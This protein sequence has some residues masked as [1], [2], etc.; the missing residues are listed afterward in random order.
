[1]PLA[2]DLDPGCFFLARR[3]P[4]A[5]H[6][7][8][9]S[10]DHKML[11]F[12]EQWMFDPLISTLC[13]S[14]G[15]RSHYCRAADAGTTRRPHFIFPAL[16]RRR[17]TVPLAGF[18]P[19]GPSLGTSTD[20]SL[21]TATPPFASNVPALPRDLREEFRY[22]RDQVIE[23]PVAQEWISPQGDSPAPPVRFPYD[24][25]WASIKCGSSESRS[26]SVTARVPARVREFHVTSSVPRDEF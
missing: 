1:V 13:R 10:S 20:G 26:V 3:S 22:F 18:S 15:R 2:R 19:D 5:R 12:F 4:R 21:P 25:V 6:E 14:S 7:Q 24:G 16:L 17:H 9:Q 8:E 11:R 23:W